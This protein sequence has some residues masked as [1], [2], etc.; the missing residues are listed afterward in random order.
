MREDLGPVTQNPRT[1]AVQ[2]PRPN[3]VGLIGVIFKAVATAAPIAAMAGQV[4]I[5]VGF[6]GGI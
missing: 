6:G 1:K 5:A 3:A 2:R 4:P